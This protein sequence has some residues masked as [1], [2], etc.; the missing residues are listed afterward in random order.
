MIQ[1][2]FKA[3]CIIAI[4]LLVIICVPSLAQKNQ[5]ELS[6][7]I[8]YPDGRPATG[9]KV[10]IGIPTVMPSGCTKYN[11]TE[12]ISDANGFYKLAVDKTGSFSIEVATGDYILSEFETI[13]NDGKLQKNTKFLLNSACLILGE[14]VDTVTSSPIEGADI[15]TDYCPGPE[16]KS[17]VDGTFK[18]RVLPEPELDLT[19]KKDGYVTKR[20]NFSA[21]NLDTLAL[22]VTLKPG[23]VIKGRVT[24]EKGNPVA[25]VDITI[26][27]D[28]NWIRFSKTDKNGNYE[29]RNVDTDRKF[30]VWVSTKNSRS[31][32]N[33]LSEFNNGEKETRL[34]L[35]IEQSA[36]A[37]HTISGRVTDDKGLPVADAAVIFG[38]STCHSNKKETKTNK[39]GEYVLENVSDE[40]NMILVQATGYAPEFLPVDQGGNLTLDAKLSKGHFAEGKIV[41]SQGNLIPEVLITVNARTQVLGRLYNNSAYVD[42]DIYRWLYAVKSDSSGKFILKDLPSKGVMLDLSKQDYTTPRNTAIKVDSTENVLAMNGTLLLTGKAVDASTG[43]PVRGFVVKWNVGSDDNRIFN[44]PDGTFKV[45]LNDNWSLNQPPYEVKVKAKGYLTE[46]KAI[47]PIESPKVDYT[48]IFKLQKPFPIQGTITDTSGN[49]IAG[50]SV[51]IVE[52][53][54]YLYYMIPPRVADT[55]YQLKT[56]TDS[57]GKFKIGTAQERFATVMIEKASYTS[58][59]LNDIDLS[60]PVNIKMLSP[61]SLE[62]RATSFTGDKST[63]SLATVRDNCYGAEKTEPL[64]VNGIKTYST[65]DAGTYDVNVSSERKAIRRKIVLISGKKTVLDYDTLRPVIVKGTVTKLGKPA[66]NVLISIV[67]GQSNSDNSTNCKTDAQGKYELSVE[68]PGSRNLSYYLLGDRRTFSA[69]FSSAKLKLGTNTINIELPSG[70]ITGRIVDADTGRPLAGENIMAHTRKQGIPSYETPYIDPTWGGTMLNAVSATDG[71]FTIEGVP[72]GDVVLTV[73]TDTNNMQKWVGR[74]FKVGKNQKL[75][76]VIIKIAEPG[77]VEFSVVDADSGRPIAPQWA[78]IMTLD[79]M[80]AGNVNA[81][82]PVK[83]QPGNYILW[84]RTDDYHLPAYTNIEVK[85]GK[86]LKVDMKLHAVKQRIVF[87]IPKGGRLY[88]VIKSTKVDTTAKWLDDVWIGYKLTDAAT[89]K[90]VLADQGG[91]MW[92]GIIYIYT[93]DSSNPAI[94]IKPGTYILDA[95]LRHSLDD[96]VDSKNNLWHVHK[97]IVVKPGK[98][99]VIQVN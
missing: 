1:R 55:A 72:A 58:Q 80:F 30:P 53:G 3:A 56:T 64:P 52:K 39:N 94:P 16:T 99:T 70:V 91:M 42:A 28:E 6:G 40:K 4:M 78:N 81:R 85:S 31:S 74:S 2:R 61:A 54:G 26:R 79:N 13:N 17:S 10:K 43:V 65:L 18:L 60:K 32:E 22:R 84:A 48:N 97:N 89:G 41:D 19:V 71:S 83:L 82:Q 27:E 75:D 20:M 15:S 93:A 45:Q 69:Y 14:I 50:V 34:D 57:R 49:G 24:D 36:N 96:M 95:I 73:T 77:V 8:V 46:V 67:T 76:G 35:T 29:I 23:G 88:N 63:I 38:K 90:P 25:G 37:I 86:T 7:S 98:D 68:Q 66:D 33:K 92:G 59:V 9:I 12:A 47:K 5:Y 21:E 87:Q 11:Y 44:L 62:V 51:T